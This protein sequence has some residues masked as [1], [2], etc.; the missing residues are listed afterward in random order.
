VPCFAG[1]H[2]LVALAKLGFFVGIFIGSCL[3]FP[4]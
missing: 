1:S 4:K 2:Q 3:F